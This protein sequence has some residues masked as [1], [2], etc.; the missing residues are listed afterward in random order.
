MTAESRASADFLLEDFVTLDTPQGYRAELIA[1]EIV[2]TPPSNGDHEDIIGQFVKQVLRHSAAEMD[3]S[4]DKGLIIPARGEVGEGRVIPDI[5]FAPTALRLF[6]GAP[7]WMASAGVAMVA[8]V[9]SQRPGPARPGPERKAPRLR[10]GYAV[11]EI[12]LYLLVDR[13]RKRPFGEQL[14][15]PSRSNSCLIHRPSATSSPGVRRES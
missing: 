7:P 5:T 10:R 15:L 8:E 9:T 12:P 1:G 4:A 11:A 6:R 14:D 2:V 3:F 13:Q